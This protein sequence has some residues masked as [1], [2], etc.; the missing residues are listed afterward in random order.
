MS[1]RAIGRYD[2][3]SESK[4]PGPELPRSA[5]AMRGKVEIVE[6]AIPD[7]TAIGREKLQRQRAAVNRLTDPLECERSFGRISEPAYLAGRAYMA[8]CERAAIGVAAGLLEPASGAGDRDRA[9]VA[10][11]DHVRQAVDMQEGVSF[12]IG[13]KRALI[14]RAILCDGQSFDDLRRFAPRGAKHPKS[15]VAIEFRTGLEEVAV[16]WDRQGWPG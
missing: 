6:A 11:I 9:L 2:R 16:F 10:R 1:N 3:V 5:R 15:D 8:V 14:L 12:A 4:H 13:R 7:P